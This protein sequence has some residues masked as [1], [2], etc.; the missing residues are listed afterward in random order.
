MDSVCVGTVDVFM[1]VSRTF[2]W[3]LYFNGK[4]LVLPLVIISPKCHIGNC[5]QVLN[6][7]CTGLVS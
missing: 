6:V 7:D 3:G 4:I 2:G 1:T 5:Q